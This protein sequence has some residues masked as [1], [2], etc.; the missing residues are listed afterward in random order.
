MQYHSFEYL[1]KK[2]FG[3]LKFCRLTGVK[4]T[5]PFITLGWTEIGFLKKDVC[6]IENEQTQSLHFTLQFTVHEIAALIR[7]WFIL[8]ER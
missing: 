1:Q 4:Y 8:H 3:W 5:L 7:L 6:Y 2:Q